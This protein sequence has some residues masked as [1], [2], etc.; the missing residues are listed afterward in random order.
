MPTQDED[1]R[2]PYYTLR[3]L[4][5]QQHFLGVPV[6]TAG[7]LLGATFVLILLYFLA[8]QF[9]SQE[10]TGLEQLRSWL[11]TSATAAESVTPFGPLALFVVA[12]VQ[13]CIA[14][15]DL[16]PSSNQALA[17]IVKSLRALFQGLAL[18][19]AALAAGG[20]L[21]SQPDQAIHTF[22]VDATYFGIG[23]LLGHCLVYFTFRHRFPVNL[24]SP[25]PAIFAATVYLLLKTDALAACAIV[26]MAFVFYVGSLMAI[27]DK[28]PADIR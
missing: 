13:F 6:N 21:L 12:L 25:A 4:H 22:R 15:Q 18:A 27:V 9:L 16:A 26:V 28:K 1:K 24:V 10:A 23:L 5:K 14:A 7:K 2:L 3:P 20:Y 11:A 17:L 19:L 8:R